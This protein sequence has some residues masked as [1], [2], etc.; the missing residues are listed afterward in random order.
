[1][2]VGRDGPAKS[3]GTASRP[4]GDASAVDEQEWLTGLGLRCPDCDGVMV[5]ARAWTSEL[6]AFVG[7][8]C[9]SCDQVYRQAGCD[10]GGG[11]P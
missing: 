5:G 6:G 7:V 8:A 11:E 3:V 10:I 4:G 1:M 2:T 9:V